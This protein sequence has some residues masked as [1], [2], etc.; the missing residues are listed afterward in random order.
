MK[1]VR[2]FT[3]E[4]PGSTLVPSNVRRA[5]VSVTLPSSLPPPVEPLPRDEL[6]DLLPGPGQGVSREPTEGCQAAPAP[7]PAPYSPPWAFLR[8]LTKSL[9]MDT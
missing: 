9:L 7:P 3:G 5:C 2:A 1:G 8:T 4:A 6:C